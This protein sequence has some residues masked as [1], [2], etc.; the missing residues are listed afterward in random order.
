MNGHELG[1]AQ[2]L[3]GSRFGVYL[4]NL[5]NFASSLVVPKR[6]KTSGSRE[7]PIGSQLYGPSVTNR[8]PWQMHRAKLF[9]GAARC[10]IL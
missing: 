7:R 8:K 3:E 4:D 10:N 5:A 6:A 1:I 9:A 2:R